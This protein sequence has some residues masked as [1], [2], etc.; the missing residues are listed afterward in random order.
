MFL[1][2]GL[3]MDSNNQEQIMKLIRYTANFDEELITMQQYIDKM[4]KE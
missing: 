2:E 4:K 3:A 1:K